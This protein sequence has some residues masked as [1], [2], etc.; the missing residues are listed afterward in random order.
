MAYA[1]AWEPKT[2]IKRYSGYVSGA[3]FRDAVDELCMDEHFAGIDWL[4][5]DL[6]AVTTHSIDA[7]DVEYAVAMSHGSRRFNPHLAVRVA[8]IDPTLI[9]LLQSANDPEYLNPYRTAIFPTLEAARASLQ[10]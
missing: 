5:C 10:V 2:A 3:E 8:A 1:I 9:E 7:N 6:T 4:I